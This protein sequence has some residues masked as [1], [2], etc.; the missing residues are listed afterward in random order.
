M[1]AILLMLFPLLL[2]IHTRAAWVALGTAIL[3]LCSK[4][5]G[6][7]RRDYGRHVRPVQDDA[8]I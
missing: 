6:N 4:R 7:A 5:L 1:A 2:L 3:I 8:S